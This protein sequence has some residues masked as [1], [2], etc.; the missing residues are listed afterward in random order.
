MTTDGLTPDNPH[1]SGPTNEVAE[2]NAESVIATNETPISVQSIAIDCKAT[3]DSMVQGYVEA[4]IAPATRRAY[5]SDLDRFAAW[6]GTVPSTDAQVA[7]Y[8]AAHAGT[9]A[10]ATLV[11]RTRG[12]L[13]RARGARLT[14]PRSVAA[15][16]RDHA[17]HPAG[18][19]ECPASGQAAAS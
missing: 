17:R 12:D 7:G 5:R 2:V 3:L 10:V 14:E 1:L 6:G 9:L 11:R 8:L 13:S 16:P 15:R 19:G 4:G 18:A